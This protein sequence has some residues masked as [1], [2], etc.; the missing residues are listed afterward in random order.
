M[1]GSSDSEAEQSEDSVARAKPFRGAKPHRSNDSGE[2][3]EG[4]AITAEDNED[5]FI[6]EDDAHG[7]PATQLPVAFS[8]N[9]HQDLAHHF[10]IV[11][12][13]FVHMAVRPLSERRHFLEHVLKGR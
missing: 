10:K 8:M 4:S 3:D 2:S 6:V 12:Q 5:D 1:L 7:A 13:L 11:C 9:T